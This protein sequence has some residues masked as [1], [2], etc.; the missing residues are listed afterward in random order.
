MK[1]TNIMASVWKKTIFAVILCF[2][3]TVL[4]ADILCVR[5]S[6]AMT[7]GLPEPTQL[8][9]SSAV[10]SEPVL[11]GLRVNPDNPLEI[12]FIFDTA[13]HEKIT[14]NEGDRLVAYFF[15]S[16]SIAAKDLW[17]NLSPYEADRKLP[18]ALSKTAL[19]Q[20]L[21]GQDYILKQLSS[22]L[23]HPAT[24]LGETY[25][26]RVNSEEIVANRN[27][28]DKIW[29]SPGETSLYAEDHSVFIAQANLKIQSE[30][31][32]L[33][34]S[35]NNNKG[36]TKNN[37][38]VII[39]KLTDE[40]NHGKH[41]AKLRQI[42][43]S[44]ILG[45]WFKTKFKN[46]LYKS[47]INSNNINGFDTVDGQTI[48]KIY[49]LYCSAFEKGVYDLVRH[50]SSSEAVL[51]KQRYF[52]GGFTLLNQL[53]SSAIYNTDAQKS[54]V[55]FKGKAVLSSSLGKFDYKKSLKIIL[56]IMLS[57]LVSA[58]Q[59]S[60]TQIDMMNVGEPIAEL[61]VE[62][63]KIVEPL[64]RNE[65]LTDYLA[66]NGLVD[67]SSIKT[68]VNNHIQSIKSEFEL[69]YMGQMSIDEIENHGDD[70]WIYCLNTNTNNFR[71]RYINDQEFWTLVFMENPA[72]FYEFY[73]LLKD[74]TWTESYFKA[75]ENEFNIDYKSIT[76]DK[77]G[78]KLNIV[79]DELY[80]K[81]F[82]GEYVTKEDIEYQKLERRN[83]LLLNSSA[84]VI[85]LLKDDLNALEFIANESPDFFIKGSARL[86]NSNF[87]KQ[88]LKKLASKNP[89]VAF[90]NYSL[91][92][93][94][95]CEDFILKMSAFN[96]L[97]MAQNLEV[98][99]GLLL[100]HNFEYFVNRDWF[101]LFINKC[102]EQD[103]RI[104]L[105][106]WSGF[107]SKGLDISYYEKAILL[108][109]VYVIEEEFDLFGLANSQNENIK[110]F[111]KIKKDFEQLRTVN[112]NISPDIFLFMD[113]LKSGK[114]ISDVEEYL[115]HPIKLFQILIELSTSSEASQ[116]SIQN[117]IT[118]L[119]DDVFKHFKS[120]SRTQLK[121]ELLS[122]ETQ[123]LFNILIHFG[124]KF[125][126]ELYKSI[127][128]EF[129]LRVA[130]N[131][132]LNFQ[133]INSLDMN[134]YFEFVKVL[135][136]NDKLDELLSNFD[137]QTQY[138]FIQNH[139]LKVNDYSLM[140]PAAEFGVFSLGFMDL[141]SCVSDEVLNQYLH[142][143]Q[144]D[145]V[146]L[147]NE[148]EWLSNIYRMNLE[149]FTSD[150]SNSAL[151]INQD[152]WTSVALHMIQ[153]INYLHDESNSIRFRLL[154]RIDSPDVL[155]KFM[156]YGVEEL[157]DI[158]SSSFSNLYSRLLVR[159]E[160]ENVRPK[161]LLDANPGTFRVFISL[162]NRN[163]KINSFLEIADKDYV[164]KALTNFVA[165]LELSYDFINQAAIVC[166]TITDI[167]DPQLISLFENLL[168]NEYL[169]GQQ[170]DPAVE[171]IYGNMLA[172]F[173]KANQINKT[174]YEE[175][176]KKF[177]Y[178]DLSRFNVDDYFN[179]KN[180]VVQRYYF[181]GD[182]D[183]VSSFNHMIEKYKGQSQWEV[184]FYKTYVKISSKN[185]RNVVLYI[186]NP[187]FKQ[188][189]N[190]A[191]NSLFKQIKIKTTMLVHRGHSYHLRK[192][193]V[194][195]LSE[196]L[197]FSYLGSCGGYGRVVDVLETAMLSQILSTRG[198]GTMHVNDELLKRINE[199]LRKGQDFRWDEFWA[200][201]DRYFKNNKSAVVYAKFK[202]YV[203]P[204]KNYAAMLVTA[205]L[206]ED[207]KPEENSSAVG[208]IYFASIG[209][210]VEKSVA[211]TQIFD[212]Y[213]SLNFILGE[214]TPYKL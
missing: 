148:N 34:R 29:I 134:L 21:L 80:K 55:V 43:H 214:F 18:D 159:M 78:D 51:T 118:T 108:D 133:L 161:D 127:F 5:E 189:G 208:G 22:S 91:Y 11:K 170:G 16:L 174:E 86:D 112:K 67:L 96:T 10:F 73:H 52:S 123:D 143:I 68:R 23:T 171:K 71:N 12:D 160:K 120:L 76:Q 90:E 82:F 169:R 137:E 85:N 25:W 177:S 193:L 200:E 15:A 105:S 152:Y 54:E 129:N 150:N 9:E 97:R 2:L 93:D 63:T 69:E 107:Q 36:S 104:V 196:D 142:G 1:C 206:A 131:P 95:Q 13:N 202:D 155:F 203:P 41:F 180:M 181:Y 3:V 27:A 141:L 195:A 77:N 157:D 99:F 199:K 74:Q 111:F 8:L 28:F 81:G 39:P 212:S 185:G 167:K 172:I 84:F 213:R 45:M 103:A 17:V 211:V 192:T 147:S 101:D 106:N 191:I 38:N 201:M 24:P 186:N 179:D 89:D 33:A 158:Y 209:S 138:E 62:Q 109:P 4:C 56:P 19:G 210:S 14:K 197:M 151:A 207:E 176:V 165:N 190:E 168:Y 48:D 184:T 154:D 7:L 153:R 149:I 60:F 46:S 132:Y 58:C 92:K 146:L 139:Q 175:V 113:L 47:Y 70:A 116:R 66:K 57:L 205:L 194:T 135:S 72:A 53:G 114:E 164:A 145:N 162:L 6:D 64:T 26:S 140:N 65:V 49:N 83:I 204:H 122:M 198:T 156:C 87:A 126:V 75:I 163:N 30:E 40:L 166:G 183:G 182:K 32:Y 31:D 188:R 110:S 115:G 50:S 117:K 178:E 37:Q 35:K 125:D 42:Y 130:D 88:V 61:K 20:D 102:I 98:G 128:D 94:L 173:L 124:I 187:Y 79:F 144:E 119:K 121:R 100:E 136:Q 59:K 44:L